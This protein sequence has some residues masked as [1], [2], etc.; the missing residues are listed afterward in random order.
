MEKKKK[1]KSKM[2]IF[3]HLEYKNLYISLINLLVNLNQEN[4]SFQPF[5][6]FALFLCLLSQVILGMIAP[7]NQVEIFDF[8]PYLT[9]INIAFL[10]VSIVEFIGLAYI[11]LVPIRSH[12]FLYFN[13][14][15]SLYI[16]LTLI[17]INIVPLI[18]IL[19]YLIVNTNKYAMYIDHIAATFCSLIIVLVALYLIY[20]TTY[21]YPPMNPT[22]CIYCPLRFPLQCIAMFLYCAATS[23]FMFVEND[24]VRLVAAIISILP[25]ICYIYLFIE[26][27]SSLKSRMSSIS[28]ALS[29]A[30]LE[31]SVSNIIQIYIQ[32]PLAFSYFLTFVFFFAGLIF[33]DPIQSY[34]ILKKQMKMKTIIES[35]KF[36]VLLKEKPE[37]IA[38]NIYI[39]FEFVETYA[40]VDFLLSHFPLE[41]CFYELEFTLSYKLN[42]TTRMKNATD[43]MLK[44]ASLST[45]Q[46]SRRKSYNYIL[47]S[48][49]NVS[50]NF[51]IQSTKSAFEKYTKF[52]SLFWNEI[53]IDRTDYLLG[54]CK[55]ASIAFHTLESI[56]SKYGNNSNIR[57]IRRKF[58][59][60]CPLKKGA[61]NP[62]QLDI[63]ANAR[64]KNMFERILTHFHF[65]LSFYLSFIFITTVIVFGAQ[66]NSEITS[67]W[68]L[69]N[70]FGNLMEYYEEVNYIVNT[71]DTEN[72]FPVSAI[73]QYLY[74]NISYPS[75]LTNYTSD[76]FYILDKLKQE[77]QIFAGLLSDY[78]FYDVIEHIFTREMNYVVNNT[79]SKSVTLLSGIRI[80]IAEMQNE[81]NTEGQTRIIDDYN[82]IYTIPET[83]NALSSFLL[84][85]VQ[86]YRKIY[87]ITNCTMLG[88]FL[89]FLISYPFILKNIIDTFFSSVFYLPKTELVELTKSLK[90][91]TADRALTTDT[92]T[93]NPMELQL[94]ANLPILDYQN[95]N[96]L[97][98]FSTQEKIENQTAITTYSN[99]FYIFYRM[100]MSTCHILILIILALYINLSLFNNLRDFAKAIEIIEYTQ[101]LPFG[102]IRV[103]SMIQKFYNL[104]DTDSAEKETVIQQMS[105]LIQHL[106][107][108]TNTGTKYF[109]HYSSD[110]VNLSYFRLNTMDQIKDNKYSLFASASVCFVSVYTF[111]SSSP[112]LYDTNFWFA[113]DSLISTTSFFIP[114][115]KTNV[116]K[117]AMNFSQEMKINLA[118]YGV[119]SFILLLILILVVDTNQ[120]TLINPNDAT[121]CCIATMPASVY[122][123]FSRTIDNDAAISERKKSNQQLLSLLNSPQIIETLQTPFALIDESNK[124]V[125]LPAC[126]EKQYKLNPNDFIKRDLNDLITYIS[127]GKFEL[128]NV[129]DKKSYLFKL[130]G[131]NNISIKADQFDI[132]PKNENFGHFTSACVFIDVSLT[133]KAYTD[134]LNTIN[135]FKIFLSMQ[136]PQL[137]IDKVFTADPEMETVSLS[138]SCI[139][140]LY[141]GN[142]KS[143]VQA[144]LAKAIIR[145]AKKMIPDCWITYHSTSL[146]RVF[147]GLNDYKMFNSVIRVLYFSLT[148]MTHLQN[149]NISPHIFIS[150]VEDSPA[151]F[152]PKQIVLYETFSG[153]SMNA[154][155]TLMAPPNQVF[156]SRDIYEIIYNTDIQVTYET[157]ITLRDASEILY[158]VNANAIQLI[159]HDPHL[160]YLTNIEPANNRRRDT[161]FY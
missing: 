74:N 149:L 44:L 34:F 11:L 82:V 103:T 26:K 110:I 18:M 8:S 112:A 133:L 113:M 17:L 108:I 126:I 109:S 59:N 105:T 86:H 37:T 117:D 30:L 93:I 69:L 152:D 101:H 71:F 119:F 68:E 51:L 122:A 121:W 15:W 6:N 42:N 91:M 16:P 41:Y 135:Q 124:I 131:K 66:L 92:S 21:G 111:Q 64:K 58:N 123:D 1:E 83:V 14:K 70:H 45:L 2:F 48:K 115:L 90:Y 7:P 129:Q 40:I 136:L 10:L 79:N 65:Y 54:I 125:L 137:C 27:P 141:L 99:R 89:V 150:K 32:I 52:I 46:K 56:F 84:D 156:I 143:A 106:L 24:I 145:E 148:A 88:I 23:S 139:C 67:T 142:L 19:V 104:K 35:N 95:S 77:I 140:T 75:G 13:K 63:S 53:I 5:Y 36:D 160:R 147:V 153:S 120:S 72:Q 155:V 3:Y 159:E 85:R 50:E 9:K 61:E 100:F 146:L 33:A 55:Q 57:P 98:I 43:K 94:N 157:M 134:W 96:F 28:F 62:Y 80:K 97:E 60:I 78:K 114:T 151:K 76:A 87:F 25:L 138:A 73:S 130:R 116:S 81:L 12:R 118:L 22:K 127:D 38:F 4:G 49:S 154:L 144:N 128:K 158:R 161:V 102:L 29:F 47:F 107:Q 132:E 20:L 31:V 39:A